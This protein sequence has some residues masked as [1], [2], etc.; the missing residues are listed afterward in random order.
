MCS[1]YCCPCYIIFHP[2]LLLLSTDYIQGCCQSRN[3]Y[4]QVC[5][6]ESYIEKNLPIIIREYTVEKKSLYLGGKF[7]KD[8][9][10]HFKNN[11]F[12]YASWKWSV[13]ICCASFIG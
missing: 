13:E 2:G 7:G 11:L 6:W 8:F 3:P 5:E 1:I 9:K 12:W 10:G 4:R